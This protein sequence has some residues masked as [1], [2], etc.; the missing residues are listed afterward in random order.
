MSGEELSRLN[1]SKETLVC[2]GAFSLNS[3]SPSTRWLLVRMGLHRQTRLCLL[4][5]FSFSSLLY[6]ILKH[7]ALAL[8][9][10]LPRAASSLKFQHFTYPWQVWKRPL[11]LLKTVTN[12]K[13]N[14]MMYLCY[15]YH[16]FLP[17]RC[18]IR[19]TS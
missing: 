17:A 11:Y 18:F 12:F 6:S 5:R 8:E 10:T 2:S 1:G 7:N 15:Y 13:C 14:L 4:L 16:F 19:V 3:Q 9:L